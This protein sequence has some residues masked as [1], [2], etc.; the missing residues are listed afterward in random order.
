MMSRMGLP[1]ESLSK[2]SNHFVSEAQDKYRSY[3]VAGEHP[4]MIA[5]FTDAF[6][7]AQPQEGKDAHYVTTNKKEF[8][9]KWD[10]LHG[11]D[12]E[13]RQA[14]LRHEAML[15]RA[16]EQARLEAMNKRKRKGRAKS[17]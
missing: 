13:S 12:E 15:Q 17:A 16:E 3:V 5:E 11:E 9:N 1:V 10:E 8:W 14:R 6:Y 2:K 4:G 7:Q